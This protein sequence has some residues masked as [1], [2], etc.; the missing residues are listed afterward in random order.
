MFLLIFDSSFT[1]E[2]TQMPHLVQLG[3]S[4]LSWNKM[5]CKTACQKLL[6]QLHKVEESASFIVLHYEP[7]EVNPDQMHQAVQFKSNWIWSFR[8]RVM[9]PS[10]L[11]LL[12][13][14]WLK[15]LTVA[16]NVTQLQEVTLSGHHWHITNENELWL[17][18]PSRPFRLQPEFK[19]ILPKKY[20]QWYFSLY[21]TSPSD[22]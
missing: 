21:F 3:I 10:L 14:H 6:L 15:R 7:E 5:A 2:V 18:N 9:P 4:R 11:W 16:L 20:F 12:S 13:S 8:H 19:H 1:G 17:E 22:C